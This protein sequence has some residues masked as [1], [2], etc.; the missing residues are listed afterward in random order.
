MIISCLQNVIITQLFKRSQQSCPLSSNKFSFF[1]KSPF[2]NMRD[3]NINKRS[4]LV[5]MAFFRIDVYIIFGFMGNGVID[6]QLN[7]LTISISFEIHRRSI[8]ICR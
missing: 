3:T 7:N 4:I 6:T 5:F 2:V 1:V 8:A